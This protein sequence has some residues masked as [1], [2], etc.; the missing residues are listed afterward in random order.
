MKLLDVGQNELSN[1]GQVRNW[2]LVVH[3]CLCAALICMCV[4]DRGCARAMVLCL[5]SV[6]IRQNFVNQ[7]RTVDDNNRC[8]LFRAYPLNGCERE[9]NH[10]STSSTL[11]LST[12]K[13][14]QTAFCSSVTIY[15]IRNQKTAHHQTAD[16]RG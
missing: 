2:P 15:E 1:R 11:I 14:P 4:C 12:K 5:S 10:Y 3:V 9:W 7:P 13:T 6:K 8:A 16:V